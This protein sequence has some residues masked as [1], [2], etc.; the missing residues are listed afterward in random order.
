MKE[1]DFHAQRMREIRATIGVSQSGLAEMLGVKANK[2]KDV[3]RCK[4]KIT[5]EL[6]K[7]IEEV[8]S[9]TLRWMTTGDGPK[10]RAESDL[11]VMMEVEGFPHEDLP[12]HAEEFPPHFADSERITDLERRVTRLEMMLGQITKVIRIDE[13]EF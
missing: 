8:S 3:E 10:T 7:K 2:I 4:A 5:P 6:A 1:N 9:F 13:P 12:E 11:G